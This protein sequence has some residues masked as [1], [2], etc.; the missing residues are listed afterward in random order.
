MNGLTRALAKE[1]APYGVRVNAV[2]PGFSA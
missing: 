1:V 2:A